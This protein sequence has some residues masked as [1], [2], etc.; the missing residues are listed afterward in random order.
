MLYRY[1]IRL[2]GEYI[3]AKFPFEFLTKTYRKPYE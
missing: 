2:H 1:Y 3:L